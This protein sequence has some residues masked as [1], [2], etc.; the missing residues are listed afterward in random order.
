MSRK[1]RRRNQALAIL[2][3]AALAGSMRGPTTM[4][5]ME[6][7]DVQKTIKNR[8]PK[9][10]IDTG[11]KTMVGS[12]VKTSVD[13]AAN[14]RERKAAIDKAASTNEKI[15]KEVIKRRDEGNL[16]PTMPKRKNQISSDFGLDLMGGAKRGKMV[17]ARGGGMAMGGM[18][19]TKLY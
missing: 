7:R 3:A 17:R 5:G 4:G 18:K 10:A 16:S 2:G 1:S 9:E 13:R 8:R 6:R 11:S 12:K 14:P 19:P 15:K